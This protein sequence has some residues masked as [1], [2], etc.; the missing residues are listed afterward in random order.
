MYSK[1]QTNKSASTALERNLRLI[2]FRLRS[3]GSRVIVMV[4]VA[5]TPTTDLA[6]ITSNQPTIGTIIIL[7]TV[8]FLINLPAGM[9]HLLILSMTFCSE[10]MCFMSLKPHNY[11]TMLL[12]SPFCR[13]GNGGPEGWSNLFKI[14]GGS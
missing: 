11:G 12:V 10:I 13:W 2:P 14:I 8:V 5:G 9:Y 1:S 6:E 4:A 7:V 3:T